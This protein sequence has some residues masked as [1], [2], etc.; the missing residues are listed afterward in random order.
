MQAHFWAQTHQ[1]AFATINF[2]MFVLCCARSSA[3]GFVRE[4]K[5][6]DRYKHSAEAVATSA[7][8]IS[9]RFHFT[10]SSTLENAAPENVAR[11]SQKKGLLTRPSSVG[12]ESY[13]SGSLTTLAQRSNTSA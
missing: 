11:G 5:P 1:L 7:S 3:K 13:S 10:I 12:V 6:G 4:N 8:R 2:A 9:S